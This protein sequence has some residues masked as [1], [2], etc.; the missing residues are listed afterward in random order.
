MQ[1]TDIIICKADKGGAT[2]IMDVIDY[3]HEGNRQL[4]DNNYHLKLDSDTTEIHLEL[5]NNG[6]NS[7]LRYR[8][9]SEK[10]ANGLRMGP[11]VK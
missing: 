3:I 6:I 2:V 7:L 4:D 10:L 11:W 9:I 8:H 1:R 5:V